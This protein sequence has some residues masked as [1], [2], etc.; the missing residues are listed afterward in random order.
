MNDFTT[1][2]AE[3]AKTL[4]LLSEENFIA[5]KIEWSQERQILAMVFRAQ[6]S[7]ALTVEKINR[8]GGA[9]AGLQN[10][11]DLQEMLTKFARA[12][13]LR[14]YVKQGRKLYEVNY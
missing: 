1:R 14:S 7:A 4:E 5:K 10:D 6:W 8:I 12:K 2:S 9:L 3:E 11:P 13:I